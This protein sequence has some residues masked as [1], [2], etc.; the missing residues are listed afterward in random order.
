M[1]DAEVLAV[2]VGFGMRVSESAG[3]STGNENRKF[4]RQR[5]LFLRELVGKLFEVHTAN[6][7]HGDEVN[8]A[9]FAEMISLN[10]VG[11]DE[12]GDQFRF[13]DKVFDEDL[14]VGEILAN[15]LDRDA[16]G[17]TA[18]AFLLTFVNNAHPAFAEFA[19]DFIVKVALDGEQPGHGA[20]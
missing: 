9:R 6:Q 17:E 15:D 1:N 10:D 8:A 19:K 7:F 3:D 5:M 11:V 4:D 13:A 18:S 2:F 16:L 20:R 12:V 14:L